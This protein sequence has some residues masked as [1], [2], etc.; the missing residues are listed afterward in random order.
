MTKRYAVP[1]TGLRD[2]TDLFLVSELFCY[3]GVAARL[4]V[5]N[6]FERLPNLELERR[7][8]QVKGQNEPFRI[9]REIHDYR[10][11]RGRKLL[12]I[13]SDLRVWKFL[14]QAARQLLMRVA[15]CHAADAARC[16]RPAAARG[17]TR[18]SYS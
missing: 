14:R 15:K 1:R 16:G 10:I 18:R 4:A 2:G 9:A 5:R 7:R 3:F 12:G 13:L 11:D 8:L 6:V 17:R